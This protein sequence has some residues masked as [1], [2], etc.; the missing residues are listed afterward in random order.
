M[1]REAYRM[2]REWEAF[3][4]LEDGGPPIPSSSLENT[5][6]ELSASWHRHPQLTKVCFLF[7][8]AGTEFGILS[9]TRCVGDPKLHSLR[10]EECRTPLVERTL[11]SCAP[12]LVPM[13]P[14]SARVLDT[15]ARHAFVVPVGA[16]SHRFVLFL[17]HSEPA[18]VA[19][20]EAEFRPKSHL[21]DGYLYPDYARFNHFKRTIQ[22]LPDLVVHRNLET[23]LHLLRITAYARLISD[24]L[25]DKHL[26]RAIE[27]YAPLHDIGKL[28]VPDSILLK[29][30]RLSAGEYETI[31]KHPELGF[32]IVET[33]VRIFGGDQYLPYFDSLRAIVLHHHET[34]DGEGY[35]HRLKGTRIPIEA[36]IVA[37]ADVFD[38]LTGE[39]P[40]K[41]QYTIDEAFAE[42]E[43]LRNLKLDADCVDAMV[44]RRDAV[45]FILRRPPPVTSGDW[46][47][48]D[49]DRTGAAPR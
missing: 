20:L 11:A 14:H 1:E 45:E 22:L 46:R 41:Q 43:R 18:S 48:S 37:V 9:F 39:R 3:L 34:M 17:F 38:A 15:D 32:E 28:A 13:D 35:P 8:E 19:T 47:R 27:L 30:G 36:R 21:L 7:V 5:A 40:Y 33:V 26:A 12:S 49:T 25:V 2:R 16:N 44:S 24:Q 29:P 42:L 6:T 4:C 10:A 23:G 31:R